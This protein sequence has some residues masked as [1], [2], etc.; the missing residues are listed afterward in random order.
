MTD[1]R[2]EKSI[3]KRLSYAFKS[4]KTNNKTKQNKN[5]SHLQVQYALDVFLM[6]CGWSMGVSRKH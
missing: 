6:D 2:Q 5:K 3:L 4:L 1:K